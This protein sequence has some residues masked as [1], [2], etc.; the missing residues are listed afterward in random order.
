MSSGAAQQEACIDINTNSRRL[1]TQLLI[2]VNRSNFLSENR[3]PLL[4]IKSKIGRLLA[5]QSRSTLER[6]LKFFTLTKFEE[7]L[8]LCNELHWPAENSPDVIEEA[9]E[10]DVFKF[11]VSNRL[12][13]TIP[14]PSKQSHVEKTFRF[15]TLN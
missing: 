5:Q 10:W 8:G 4:N 13:R 11:M 7:N 15:R 12:R 14:Q 6:F 3:S 2:L 1:F 9:G